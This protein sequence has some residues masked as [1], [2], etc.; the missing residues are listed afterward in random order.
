MKNNSLHIHFCIALFLLIL[1]G[2]SNTADPDWTHFRGSNLDG[3]SNNHTSPLQW[4]IDSNIVWKKEIHGRGWSS[5]VVYD[6]Q[7]W[8]TT[9]SNDGKELFA[10]CLD[11]QTGELIHDVQ[12]FTPDSVYR[13]HAINTYATPTPCIEKDYIFAHFGRY[14]TAGINTADGSV[15]WRRT[16]LSCNHIQGPG[17]SPIL[18]K[19]LLIL[20]FDGVDDQ[21][22]IALNHLTGETVW[23]TERQKEP[24][25]PLTWI[26]RKAYI[27]P[28]IIQ[29]NG[30]DLLI[31]NGAAV[32]SAYDPETGEE[33]W[34]VVRGAESTIAMPFYGN[35]LVYYY[36]G[37]MIAED[38][39][40]YTEL[41]AVD[42]DG[43]GDITGSNIKWAIRSP[44]LQ[45]LT[46]VVENGLIYTINS[47]SELQCIDSKTGRIIY[48]ER[49]KGKFN[50]SP[51]Y[52]AGRIYFF[53]TKGETY[54]LEEGRKFN[55]IAK[56]KLEGEIWATPA[57]VRNNILIR[58]S[59]YLYRIG[60]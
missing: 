40:N 31:S 20:H 26:G 25:K 37:Y 28:M 35:G 2:C 52:S 9:A 32:C 45:L 11:Y 54:V 6:N 22:L 43:K 48:A 10:V 12:L 17:S 13:K 39:Q 50:A 33:I 4:G 23:R 55:V 42:P 3:I 57:F 56:N 47:E 44:I 21:Y 59:K 30:K 51:V 24:Y 53:S 16:D 1:T 27:T 19:N 5:P 8:V 15:I 46:P 36:T 58:T 18:Y 14:G 41:L 29:V 34:W 7:V 38:G 49:M 60:E